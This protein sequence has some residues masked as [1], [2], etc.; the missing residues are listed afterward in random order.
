MA[1]HLCHKGSK[2]VFSI[3]GVLRAEKNMIWTDKVKSDKQNTENFI[4]IGQGITKLWH[5]KA[6]HYFGKTVLCMSSWICNE[7][8]DDVISPLI[9]LYFIIWNYIY[10]NFVHQEWKKLDRQLIK[11]I[12]YSLLQLILLQGRH[13]IHPSMKIWNNYDFM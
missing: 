11:Y 2:L 6:L 1:S 10:S 13:T 7:Q 12:R 5:F 8:A 3:K 4:K 9:L